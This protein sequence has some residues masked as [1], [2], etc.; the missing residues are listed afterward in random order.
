MELPLH[1]PAERLGKRAHFVV[2][3]ED[4][5]TCEFE[6][7]LW[8]LPQVASVEMDGPDVGA[9]TGHRAHAAAPRLSRGLGNA[10]AAR[11]ASTRC[12]VTPERAYMDPH[13]GRGGRAAGIAVSLYGVRSERNWGCGDFRDLRSVI[14]WVA[15]ELG[16]SFVALNPL[17]AIHNR[18]PFNTSPYLPNSIFYQN[19]LYLDVEGMEDYHL[20]RRA[21]ALRAIRRKW[22]ARSKLCAPRRLSNTSG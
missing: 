2:H 22:R 9:R 15:E 3:R 17:H 6:L 14:E 21:Q 4:G 20:C 1:V 8:E 11:E 19:Y 13:L 5:V 16:A 18:R 10:W 7:N 12:I